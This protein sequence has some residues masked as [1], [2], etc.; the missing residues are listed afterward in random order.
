MNNEIA[1]DLVA[2]CERASAALSDAEAAIFRMPSGEERSQ[3]LTVLAGMFAALFSQLRAPAIQQ[4]PQLLPAQPLPEV[5]DTVL[6][7]EVEE[8]VSRLNQLELEL[9]DEALLASC[10]P[11][12]RK[13]AR[14][15]GSAMTSLLKQF[16]DVPDGFYARRVIGLV[17]NGKLESQGNLEYMRFSE[18]RLPSG[19]SAV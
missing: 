15:V 12:W 6:E 10:A 18:V 14:I 5:P 8:N 4:Y 19:T 1:K 9:I 11:S 16:P 17:E 13:V 3:H 7:P 2:A